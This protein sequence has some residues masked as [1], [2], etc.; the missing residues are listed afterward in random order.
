MEGAWPSRWLVCSGHKLVGQL[1]GDRKSRSGCTIAQR[2][3][4]L[5]WSVPGSAARK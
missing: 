3:L 1:H 5:T 2:K 4:T